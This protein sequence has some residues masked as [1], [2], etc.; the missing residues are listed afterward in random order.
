MFRDMTLKSRPLAKN[1]YM[2][3]KRELAD[4]IMEKIFADV[5]TDC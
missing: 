5:P 3:M 4:G 1:E 2:A